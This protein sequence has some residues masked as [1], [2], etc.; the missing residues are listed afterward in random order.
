MATTVPRTAKKQ[1]V[2]VSSSWTRS[3]FENRDFSSPVWPMT[4][5]CP[6]VSGE[7]TVTEYPTFQKRSPE[8]MKIFE[9]A[10]Q[11]CTRLDERSSF[12]FTANGSVKLKISQNKK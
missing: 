6:R 4:V 12:T 9:S 7:N 11:Y 1:Q 8:C 2:V 5:S 3:V 10:V